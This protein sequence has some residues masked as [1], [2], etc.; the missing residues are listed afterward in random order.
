M[1]DPAPVS[2]AI[3]LRPVQLEDWPRIHEW[4]RRS[5]VTQFQAWGPNSA[6]ETRAFVVSAV[7]AASD[8]PQTRHVLTI[9][10]G[11]LVVGLVEMTVHGVPAGVAEFGYAVHPDYWGQGI[12]TAAARLALDHAFSALKMLRVQAT[13]DPANVASVR[14]LEKLGMRLEGTLRHN[15]WL[16]DRW[17]DT[18]IF[19]MLAREWTA[20]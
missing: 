14:V 1:P 20:R 19:S 16:G 10:I 8:R 5:D 7:H 6:A 3:A 13:C 4:S 12:A 9:V 2:G 11:D 15:I 17:R 18:H